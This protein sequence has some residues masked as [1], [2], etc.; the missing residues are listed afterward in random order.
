[1]RLTHRAFR[2][3]VRR[4]LEELPPEVLAVLDNVS[5]VAEDNPTPA[6]LEHAGNEAH[7]TLL[8][9]YEGIPLTDRTNYG[10]VLPDK[11]TLFQ[12]PLEEVTSSSDELLH[13][14]KKTIVHEVA[15]HVGW[16]DEAIHRMG[17]G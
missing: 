4:A 7:A 10:M 9:L 14:I 2:R 15:H 13:E 11:I 8:G 16:S 1:M 17:Y 3:L 12:R 6:Q 5:I